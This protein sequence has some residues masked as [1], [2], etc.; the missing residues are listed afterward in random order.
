MKKK[1]KLEVLMQKSKD[2][3]EFSKKIL[4]DYGVEVD[5]YTTLQMKKG[6]V[7]VYVNTADYDRFLRL[8]HF[9]DVELN[10]KII[11]DIDISLLNLVSLIKSFCEV[12]KRAEENK[13]KLVPVSKAEKWKDC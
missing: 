5:N 6:N 9:E 1:E 2:I 11:A 4:M 13:N 12:S 8:I 3:L 7:R 10:I